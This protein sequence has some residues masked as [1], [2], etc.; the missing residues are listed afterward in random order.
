MLLAPIAATRMGEFGGQV[1][2]TD[3]KRQRVPRTD[4]KRWRSMIKIGAMLS[5]HDVAAFIVTQLGMVGAMKLQKLVYYAQAWSLVWDRRLL[6][7]EQVEAWEQGPVVRELWER[8]SRTAVVERVAGDPSKLAA[9]QRATISAVLAFYGDRS[10]S[11][12]TELSQ[13]EAPWVDARAAGHKQ[14]VVSPVISRTAMLAFFSKYPTSFRAIPESVA[15][16]NSAS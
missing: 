10:G 1:P 13:R 3:L 15:R 8:C 5:V 12:L 14:G 6:F 11:W 2:H 16:G 7:R 4:L 9:D